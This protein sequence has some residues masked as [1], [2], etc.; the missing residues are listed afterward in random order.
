MAAGTATRVIESERAKAS[1]SSPLSVFSLRRP[2]GN[3]SR[4]KLTAPIN[5]AMAAKLSQRLSTDS[6]RGGPE[7]PP[8]S[9][10]T[11]VVVPAVGAAGPI[12]GLG[13]FEVG[14]GLGPGRGH[15]QGQARHR[16]HDQQQR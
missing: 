16:H 10:V 11:L 14:M 13:L 7:V 8:V 12:R 3:T 5:T 2:A 1:L 15:A 4:G 6:Q 9:N